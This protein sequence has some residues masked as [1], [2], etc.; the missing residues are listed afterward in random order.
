V[1]QVCCKRS[2]TNRK[3]AEETETCRVIERGGQVTH[4]CGTK[5]K[6][7]CGAAFFVPST[8]HGGISFQRGA[9]VRPRARRPARTGGSSRLWSSAPAA[10]AVAPK[11]NAQLPAKAGTS[12]VPAGAPAQPDPEQADTRAAAGPRTRQHD[13]GASAP[14][15]LGSL[16]FP[17]G[18]M[19]TGVYQAHRC[20]HRCA[21][22]GRLL[23]DR[24]GR[25][26]ARIPG[27]AAGSGPLP[28]TV[29]NRILN[30]S[31]AEGDRRLHC[32]NNTQGNPLGAVVDSLERFSER[33]L[34]PPNCRVS[35]FCGRR[36][37]G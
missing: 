22:V 2:C 21:S 18:Q 4:A 28:L 7:R 14:S 8:S 20:Y 16:G 13:A 3:S 27:V 17:Y 15:V 32:L 12:G 23:K 5:S 34:L 35:A 10:P 26:Y 24:R 33:L 36:R 9:L 19:G 6:P 30:R 11:V 37:G 29:L 1:R 31:A 25:A